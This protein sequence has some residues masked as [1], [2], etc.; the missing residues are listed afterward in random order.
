M[1]STERNEPYDIEFIRK[2]TSKLRTIL[3]EEDC[4]SVDSVSI[5]LGQ[6]DH[7]SIGYDDV[8][9]FFKAA[10]EAVPANMKSKSVILA[11]ASAIGN[12]SSVKRKADLLYELS[13][14]AET[15]FFVQTVFDPKKT[16]TSSKLS[17][18]YDDNIMYF[19]KKFGMTE[20]TVN[21]GSD[22]PEWMSPHE[23][24]VWVKDRGFMHV[25]MNQAINSATV[26]MWTE[27]Y[28]SVQQWLFEWLL[29]FKSDPSYEINFIPFLSKHMKRKNVPL[30][31]SFPAIEASFSENVYLD[32]YGNSIPSQI[33]AV[34]NLVPFS[35]RKSNERRTT[36]QAAIGTMSSLNSRTSC[37]EC[38][39]QS[40]C[41]VSGAVPSFSF[42][43]D[44]DCPWARF[45]LLSFF[46]K[47]F[48]SNGS[49]E[50]RLLDTAFDKNPSQCESICRDGN[51][52]HSY[53]EYAIARRNS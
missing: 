15:P 29:E 43:N 25:E 13:V 42:W 53:F 33:G 27:H 21:L 19:K 22:I 34:S 26:C 7:F 49:F 23:F 47:E 12:R 1:D 9:S 31:D 10:A 6:G 50:E 48:L 38:E 30:I 17:L 35:Q 18:G 39:Y 11:T 41:A 8:E 5:F 51:A 32:R 14:T 44:D 52:T 40:V 16:K 2:Q 28:E 37:L 4:D 45:E 24:H 36:K 46:E 20:L 3:E